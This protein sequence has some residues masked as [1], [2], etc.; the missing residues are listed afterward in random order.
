M[1]GSRTGGAFWLMLHI[2]A[3]VLSDCYKLSKCRHFCFYHCTA[4]WYIRTR[5]MP[6]FPLY[7][8]QKAKARSYA[9]LQPL[10]LR[11]V[12][13]MRQVFNSC[14]LNKLISGL[15]QKF[16]DCYYTSISQHHSQ[17]EE[18]TFEVQAAFP[19]PKHRPIKSWT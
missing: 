5:R 14:L 11:T 15:P 18:H 10:H 2:Q 1:F 4:P 7:W 8:F 9:P 19:L 16:K 12:A 13:S 6:P 3:H 17:R